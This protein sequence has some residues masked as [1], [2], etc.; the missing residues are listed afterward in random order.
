MPLVD[1]VYFY[2]LARLLVDAFDRIVYK[3]TSLAED[4]NMTIMRLF[5]NAFCITYYQHSSTHTPEEVGCE[6][7]I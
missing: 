3:A 5:N 7:L 4:G 1:G 2:L 6:I